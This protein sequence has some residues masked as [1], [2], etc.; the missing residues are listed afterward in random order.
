MEFWATIYGITRDGIT[1]NRLYYSII[2]LVEFVEADEGD[3]FNDRV[4]L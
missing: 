2:E 1:S 3:Q 4:H